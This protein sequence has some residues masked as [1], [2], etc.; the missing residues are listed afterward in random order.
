M[1]KGFDEDEAVR[2]KQ[3]REKEVESLRAAVGRLDCLLAG[4]T[5][6]GRMPKLKLRRRFSDEPGSDE[7]TP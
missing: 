1:L 3:A 6:K 4:V 5:G 7:R 2:R